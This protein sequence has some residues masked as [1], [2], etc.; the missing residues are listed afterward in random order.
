MNFISNL[1]GGSSANQGYNQGIGAMSDYFNKAAGYLEP[2]RNFG[3]STALPGLTDFI[4]GGG[5]NMP[6]AETVSSMPGYQF[7]LNEGLKALQNSALSR[8]NLF[9]GNTMKD[10]TRY[11]QDY[12][13]SQWQNYM[14][15]NTQ[16]L[17]NWLNATGLGANA[18]SGTGNYAMN[19]GN[20]IGNAMIGQGQN[21]AAY[22]M[23]PWQMAAQ[24]A[25]AYFGMNPGGS[26]MN[27]SGATQWLK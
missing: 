23:A 4:K 18:A 17:N 5:L 22:A 9:S 20:N 19:A 1:L 15:Q 11:G 6:T 3:T 12:A 14:N 24:G 7:N 21:N 27:A 10:I 26:G 25:G 2:Y 8:G 13:G 16:L